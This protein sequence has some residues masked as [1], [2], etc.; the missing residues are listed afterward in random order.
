MVV[1]LGVLWIGCVGGARAASLSATDTGSWTPTAPTNL[2]ATSLSVSNGGTWGEFTWTIP[3][4]VGS[5]DVTIVGYTLDAVDTSN[6][7]GSMQYSIDVDA[8]GDAAGVGDWGYAEGL[9]AGDT[10]VFTITVDYSDAADDQASAPAASILWSGLPQA[11]VFVTVAAGD[12]SATVDWQAPPNDGGS[13]ITGYD[14]ELANVDTVGDVLSAEVPASQTSYTFSGLAQGVMWTAT[15]RS[16]TASGAGPEISSPVPVAVYDAAPAAAAPSQPQAVSAVAGN[17]VAQVEWQPPSSDGGAAIEAYTVTAVDQSYAPGGGQTLTTANGSTTSGLVAGL[18][19]GDEYRFVV[20]ASNDEGTSQSATS[21]AVTPTGAVPVAPQSASATAL[22]GSGS[23]EVDWLGPSGNGGS[24]TVNYS[25]TITATDL[26]TPANGGEVD[27]ASG[28]TNSTIVNGLTNGDSYVFTVVAFNSAGSSFGVQTRAVVPFGPPSQPTGVVVHSGDQQATISWK[29]PENDGDSPVTGYTVTATD[30]TDISRGGQQLTVTGTSAELT[31]LSDGDSY[32]VAITAHNG[33][34]A[35][36][37]ADSSAFTVG[38]PPNPP[39]DVLARAASDGIVITWES[40]AGNASLPTTKYV[41][42][43][44]NVETDTAVRSLTVAATANT[45]TFSGL[46]TGRYKFAVVAWNVAGASTAAASGVLDYKPTN[47]SDVP[48]KSGKV[49]GTFHSLKLMVTTAI[50]A[51]TA[52]EK[53]SIRVSATRSQ[54]SQSPRP[55]LIEVAVKLLGMPARTL[56]H[57]PATTTFSLHEPSSGQHRLR[58]DFEF[59]ERS[60]NGRLHRLS[61]T[62]TSNAVACA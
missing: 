46:K 62:L 17:G 4:M 3:S 54:G 42:S 21:A 35:S 50:R 32:A 49:A 51:C 26:T 38:S 28:L 60:S 16:V 48:P 30:L 52:P 47:A 31:G 56:K 44:I 43:A 7:N 53:L 40:G 2:T 9:T 34:G 11:P 6:A 41:I 58:V 45:A 5:G 24:Q 57:L 1:V 20:T 55:T 10:Y 36:V 25:Y 29:Q 33:W 37:P 61:K 14:V 59:R 15:L 12:G 18:I 8:V 13:P 23:V 19:N 22:T 39:S 27:V